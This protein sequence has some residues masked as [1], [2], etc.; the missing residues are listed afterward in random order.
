MIEPW[1]MDLLVIQPKL[2]N[3]GINILTVILSKTILMNLLN[4][5]SFTNIKSPKKY[6][7]SYSADIFVYFRILKSV[8]LNANNNSVFKVFV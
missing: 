1:E 5:V 8:M 6:V 3:K 2:K 7:E 4:Q